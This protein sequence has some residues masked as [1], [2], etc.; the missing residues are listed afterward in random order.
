MGLSYLYPKML[1]QYEVMFK[2]MV[3]KCGLHEPSE[4]GDHH[5]LD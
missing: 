2:E 5:E 3:P 1:S 4:H